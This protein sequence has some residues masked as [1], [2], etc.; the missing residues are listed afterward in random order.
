[1]MTSV[2]SDQPSPVLARLVSGPLSNSKVIGYINPATIPTT[3]N[4]PKVSK[5]LILEF[6]IMNIPGKKTSVPFKAVAIDPDTART[7]LATSVD[8]HYM[9]RYGTFFAA[10][11]LSGLG[12][13]ISMQSQTKVVTGNG[14]TD[15]GR[16]EKFSSGD[17]AKIAIGKTGE[18]LA[19]SMNFLEV[20]PTIRIASG[21]AIGI[22]LQSDLV[23]GGDD[24]QDLINK[25][26]SKDMTS[27]PY[28][29]I[30]S[31]DSAA[32]ASQISSR[33]AIYGTGN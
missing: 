2:N 7:S 6:N 32:Q 29:P 31:G 27:Y 5:A 23:L 28:G 10:N 19:K 33:D 4:A 22:L 11:F 1:M 18:A 15:I 12:Q 20:P 24:T 21:T 25:S 30:V 3:S 17:E 16:T 9:L 14:T 13:A 26:L 8:N